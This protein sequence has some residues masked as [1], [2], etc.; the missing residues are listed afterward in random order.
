MPSIEQVMKLGGELTMIIVAHFFG[1]CCW[2][3]HVMG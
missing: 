3:S 2:I 1:E